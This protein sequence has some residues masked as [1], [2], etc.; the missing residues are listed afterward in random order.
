MVSTFFPLFVCLWWLRQK[1]CGVCSGAWH[2]IKTCWHC[3]HSLAWVAQSN[4]R[5]TMPFHFLNRERRIP[6]P[7]PIFQRKCMQAVWIW[8]TS[9]LFVCS[10]VFANLYIQCR[11]P[12]VQA[13]ISVHKKIPGNPP[14]FFSN[15]P[16]LLI[17]RGR[18]L[19]QLHGTSSNK[20]RKR[21]HVVRVSLWRKVGAFFCNF[22]FSSLIGRKFGGA[23][24]SF[25]L[26]FCDPRRTKKQKRYFR[27][28]EFVKFVYSHVCAV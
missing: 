23:R 16:N 6:E 8:I 18:E 19:W 21:A 25:Y 9:L 4:L 13:K 5:R 15:I 28:K 26:S 14:I 12:C 1:K 17:C 10:L 2:A 22:A 20:T 7:W 27:T 3:L 11:N 24:N